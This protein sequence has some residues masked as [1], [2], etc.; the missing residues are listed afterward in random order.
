MALSPGSA[1]PR[2]SARLIEERDQYGRYRSCLTC[3]YVDECYLGPA[4]VPTELATG[5]LHYHQPVH[6]NRPL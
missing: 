3:G 4:I 1:C 6:A 2:C 5:H